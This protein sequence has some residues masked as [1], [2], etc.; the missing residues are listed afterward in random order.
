M[1]LAVAGGG[2]GGHLFPGLAVAD[3]ARSTGLCEEIVF[4]GAERGIEA[5]LVPARGYRLIAQPIE[6]IRGGSPVGA[7]R[8]LARLVSAAFVARRELRQRRIDVVLGLGGYASSAAVVGAVLARVPVVLMEQN[9]EPGLSNRILA[10]LARAV[11]TSFGDTE[12][13]LPRGRA[14][15]TGNP[16]R[17]E[18][19]TLDD[20]RARDLLLVFG[21]SG[22]ARSLNRAAARA[23]VRLARERELPAVLHQ[24]GEAD[25]EEV[26]D[27][28]EAAGL[29]VDVRP[30]IDDMAAAY[31][32]ARLAVC[33]AGATTIAELEATATPSLL[34]PFPH[35]AG[36]HQTANAKALVEAGAARLVVDDEGAAD[37]LYDNLAELLAEPEKLNSM[38]IAAARLRR[39]RAAERVLRVLEREVGEGGGDPLS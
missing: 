23:I 4:F 29:D 32:R 2:T 20:A 16:V 27:A 17:A 22:G 25:R 10:R 3:L 39:P 19:E 1:R 15:L 38:I 26:R 35:A 12:R 9:R 14:R 34:V 36:D 13:W 5:R 21:G 11:C 33:R 31:S 8:A 18:L 6:G 24:T 28:Y 30:F 37:A 7:L